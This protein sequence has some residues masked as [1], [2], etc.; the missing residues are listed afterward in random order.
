LRREVQEFVAPSKAKQTPEWLSGER[1]YELAK[2]REILRNANATHEEKAVAQ[3]RL[4][5]IQ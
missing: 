1:S 4:K 5:D 3:A 2:A